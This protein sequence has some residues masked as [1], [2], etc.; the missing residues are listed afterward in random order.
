MKLVTVTVSA[1]P[2][3]GM[4]EI[5]QRIFDALN[6]D[7]FSVELM[8]IVSQDDS[9]TGSDPKIKVVIREHHLSKSG[10]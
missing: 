8:G 7:K 1:S 3:S 10:L 9:F 2:G 6:D 5:S 4:G